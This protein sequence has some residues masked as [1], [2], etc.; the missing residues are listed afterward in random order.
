MSPKRLGIFPLAC[1]SLVV[2]ASA[3]TLLLLKNPVAIGCPGA[4]V[5]SV[6]DCEAV[7]SSSGGHVFGMPLGFWA[8]LWLVLYWIVQWR[9]RQRATGIVASLA[10]LGVAYA[11]GT[12][13]HVGHL[14]VWCSVDQLSILGLSIW[15]L[16]REQ[17]DPQEKPPRMI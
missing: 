4:A 16:T 3:A 6:I 5:S 10:F 9:A 14:C 7:V 12:E 13:L 17:K 2:A 11:V 15:G 8:L 1:S